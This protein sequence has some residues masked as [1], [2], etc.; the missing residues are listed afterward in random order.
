MW[1]TG[2]IQHEPA[3]RIVKVYLER[4]RS[5]PLMGRYARLPAA[6]RCPLLAEI[7]VVTTPAVMKMP[8]TQ[9]RVFRTYARPANHYS[10]H[11]AKHRTAQLTRTSMVE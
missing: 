4:A 2:G 5:Q 3:E 6:H 1:V 7:P 10:V 11:I 8:S 9:E